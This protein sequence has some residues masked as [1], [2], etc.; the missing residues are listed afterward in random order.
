M[1]KGELTGSETIS[2]H[3]DSERLQISDAPRKQN[4]SSQFE[5]VLRLTPI[6]NR[7]ISGISGQK[8][9]PE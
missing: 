8:S 4:E 6:E 9:V 7:A 3:A 5:I 2:I 1:W